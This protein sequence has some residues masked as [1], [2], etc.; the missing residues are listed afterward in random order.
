MEQL[1]P[2]PPLGT[3]PD[4]SRQGGSASKSRLAYKGEIKRIGDT[5]SR[6]GHGGENERLP[7]LAWGGPS[8]YGRR[9]PPNAID[10]SSLWISLVNR[11]IPP[12]A[13]QWGF[14]VAV[15]LGS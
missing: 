2:S 12:I 14:A 7:A 9:R 8:G 5:S 1:R 15:A 6:V 10:Q 13:R 3:G 4:P 11:P